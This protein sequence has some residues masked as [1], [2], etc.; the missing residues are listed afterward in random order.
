MFVIFDVE[1][2]LQTP[3]LQLFIWTCRF[4]SVYCVNVMAGV[5]IEMDHLAG[6]YVRLSAKP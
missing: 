6:L 5:R 2:P 4:L 1:S 3:A